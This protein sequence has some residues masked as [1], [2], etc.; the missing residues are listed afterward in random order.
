MK[1]YDFVNAILS[2][3]INSGA[4]EQEYNISVTCILNFFSM[5]Y[6]WISE[7]FN[8]MISE[9]FYV[10]Y[11]ISEEGVNPMLEKNLSLLLIIS[12]QLEYNNY[13]LFL[14]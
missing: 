8:F 3:M 13:I 11:K 5:V 12:R 1:R 9:L 10:G 4:A 6:G 2:D 7:D 14:D